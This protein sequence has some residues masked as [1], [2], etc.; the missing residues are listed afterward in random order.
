MECIMRWRLLIE[1]FGPEFLYIKGENN[2]TA[3]ALLWLPMDPKQALPNNI[4]ESF[5]LDDLPKNAYPLTYKIL[6]NN[7]MKDKELQC[8]LKNSSQYILYMFC[9]GRKSYSL[10]CQNNKIVVPAALQKCIVEWYHMTLC[11]PGINCM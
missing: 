6:L 11:H 4:V 3:D 10:N 5:S 1:D 7:Q 9:G 2:I 8:K